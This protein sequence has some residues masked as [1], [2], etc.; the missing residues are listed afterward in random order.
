MLRRKFQIFIS[1]ESLLFSICDVLRFQVELEEKILFAKMNVSFIHMSE[2]FRGNYLWDS[3]MNLKAA[4]I[5]F[6]VSMIL[7]H[8]RA[9]AGKSCWEK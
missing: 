7:S 4:A 5:V 6:G 8:R 3:I 1:L 9:L 2:L